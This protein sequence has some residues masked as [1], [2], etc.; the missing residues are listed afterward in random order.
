MDLFKLFSIKFNL[1]S[2]SVHFQYL[3]GIIKTIKQNSKNFLNW[4]K[5]IHFPKGKFQSQTLLHFQINFLQKAA[6]I[7]NPQLRI[8]LHC[9]HRIVFNLIIS[10]LMKSS[11][12][13]EL[14]I[15]FFVSKRLLHGLQC[16]YLV[17]YNRWI[18]AKLLNFYNYDWLKFMGRNLKFEVEQFRLSFY[19]TIN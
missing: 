4:K 13:I 2:G 6:L 10:F 12:L 5:L 14:I 15:L 1:W 9:C 11:Q 18:E 8:V 17:L 19:K 16:S 7:F 3:L